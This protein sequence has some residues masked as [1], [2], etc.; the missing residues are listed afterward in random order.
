MTER[1]E[2]SNPKLRGI[3]DYLTAAL[4]DARDSEPLCDECRKPTL[5]IGLA[6]RSTSWWLCAKHMERWER[7]GRSSE[8]WRY[9][10]LKAEA[11]QAMAD[12]DEQA[13]RDFDEQIG[14]QP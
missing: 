3:V 14:P 6:P 12:R 10:K 1:L 7:Q 13:E 11:E 9:L 5:A 8:V 4:D 2:G